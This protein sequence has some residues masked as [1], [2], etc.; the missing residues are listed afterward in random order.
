[1]LIYLNSLD[2]EQ[3]DK[4]FIYYKPPSNFFI[5]IMSSIEP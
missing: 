4:S 1:M 2:Q 3:Q 5:Y